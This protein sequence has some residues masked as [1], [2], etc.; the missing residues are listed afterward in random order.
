MT[1]HM[2]ITDFDK[3]EDLLAALNPMHERWQPEPGFWCFRGQDDASLSLVPSALREAA[4]ARFEGSFDSARGFDWYE[5]MNVQ[6]FQQAA[7]HAGFHIPGDAPV[8][9]EQGLHMAYTT[10]ANQPRESWPNNDVLGVAALARHYGV[11]QWCQ[12]SIATKSCRIAIV[13]VESAAEP[14]TSY[15]EA[16][17]VDWRWDHELI[18]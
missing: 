5:Q 9:R 6:E 15:D 14:L 11:P 2:E 13:E 7:D 8:L 12:K 10:S 1:P 16:A 17:S 4:W 18:A 3:A